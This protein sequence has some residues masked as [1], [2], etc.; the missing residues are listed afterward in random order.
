MAEELVRLLVTEDSEVIES[1]IGDHC[2][3]DRAM[4]IKRERDSLIIAMSALTESL[5]EKFMPKL[6]CLMNAMAVL[7]NVKEDIV[8]RKYREPL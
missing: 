7:C 1:D 2:R 6:G 3:F 8:R 4:Q 5:D